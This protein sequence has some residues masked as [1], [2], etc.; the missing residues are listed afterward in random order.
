VSD[1]PCD[2]FPGE[3][4][5]DAD[6]T[7]V[8]DFSA[9]D[10]PG[11]PFG[12]VACMS[13]CDPLAFFGCFRSFSRSYG[14]ECDNPTGV[15]IAVPFSFGAGSAYTV[16]DT[17]TPL[18]P[19]LSTVNAMRVDL[20]GSPEA[21]VGWAG[22]Q[23]VDESD[24][25]WKSGLLNGDTGW[26]PADGEVWVFQCLAKVVADALGVVVDG[27]TLSF[28]V[29]PDGFSPGD[30]TGDELALTSDWQ[31]FQ[32]LFSGPFFPSASFYWPLIHFGGTIENPGP[33]TCRFFN[34]NIDITTYQP[35][36]SVLIKCAHLYPLVTPG[37]NWIDS[38]HGHG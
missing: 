22:S 18:V 12:W 20:P 30:P 3:V 16:A 11:G 38:F 26:A 36:G 19:D 29:A 34:D 13:Y 27:A 8:G 28:N 23:V 9:S 35:L 37:G 32:T 21:F 4:F 25:S 31:F 15:R 1:N 33:D 14:C 7:Y 10:G 2:L 17:S 5:A 6:G 24:G